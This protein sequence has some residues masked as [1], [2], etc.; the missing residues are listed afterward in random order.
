SQAL[1]ERFVHRFAQQVRRRVGSVMATVEKAR[2]EERAQYGE[3]VYLL[4]PNIKRSQGGLRDVQML[5]WIGFAAH[6]VASPDALQ[7]G[8][9]I[10]KEDQVL[11]RQ[12]TEF[13]LHLRNEM[14]FHAGKANDVLDRAEQVR[15]A[16]VLG[17]RGQEGLLPFEQFMR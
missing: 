2:Q 9:A 5:R 17:F 7:L 15:L 8:G 4:E 10:T 13:L 6:G 14:H 12:A 16:Q 1:Y 11:L 3:T